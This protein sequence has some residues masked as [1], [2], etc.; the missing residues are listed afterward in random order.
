VQQHIA[1]GHRFRIWILDKMWTPSGGTYSSGDP[2]TN[3]RINYADS[4]PTRYGDNARQS[5]VVELGHG[6]TIDDSAL[7]SSHFVSWDAPG[8]VKRY[9]EDSYK[10]IRI[11]PNGALVQSLNPVIAIKQMDSD[12]FRQVEVIRCTGR[13][14]PM[15]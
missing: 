10:D 15:N 13:L 12:E 7:R 1:D 9:G 5:E 14:V 4:D 11:G 2:Y 3:F 6:L 8:S